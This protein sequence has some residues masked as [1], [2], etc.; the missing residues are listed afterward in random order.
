MDKKELVIDDSN[1]DQYFFD[2]RRNKPQPGQVMACYTGIAELINAAPDGREKENLVD[3]LMQTNKAEA[4]A[5]VMRKLF[6]A[7]E[8]DA[9]RVPIQI[10]EDLLSGMNKEQ[11]LEKAYKYTLNMYFYVKPEHIPFDDP[12]WSSVNLMASGELK[13]P[14]GVITSK[15]IE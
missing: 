15:I 6:F 10:I 9:L 3:L 8:S 5:Q 12:H 14:G 4:S 7:S 2:I 13:I 1:F 11:V